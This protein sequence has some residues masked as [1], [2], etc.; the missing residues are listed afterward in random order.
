M[1]EHIKPH[2][3]FT[4]DGKNFLAIPD[5]IVIVDKLYI[6]DFEITPFGLI[7]WLSVAG[8]NNSRHKVV[9]WSVKSKK[10]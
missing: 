6:A 5:E 7:Q 9:L 3:K 1:I 4:L 10:K 2:E 8:K